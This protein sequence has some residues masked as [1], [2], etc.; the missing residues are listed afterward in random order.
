M[1]RQVWIT[2]KAG[3]IH[4]L[5]LQTQD[6]PHRKAGLLRIKLKAVGLNFADIFA[7]T[8]LYSATRQGRLLRVWNFQARF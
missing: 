8:G 4:N 5:A 6:M 2:P 1:Q 7:L 3:A